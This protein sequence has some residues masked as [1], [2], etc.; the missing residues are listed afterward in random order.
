MTRRPLT[1]PEVEARIAETEWWRGVA[2][3]DADRDAAQAPTAKPGDPQS[4]RDF[5]E[6]TP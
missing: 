1:E 2:D 3:S 4:V 6:G 5:L